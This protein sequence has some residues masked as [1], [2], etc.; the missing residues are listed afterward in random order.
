[1]NELKSSAKNNREPVVNDNAKKFV[2]TGG[3]LDLEFLEK[4][5]AVGYTMV[6]DWIE[7]GA[8]NETK[9]VHKAFADGRQEYRLIIKEV[10]ASGSRKTHRSD[11]DPDVYRE[12]VKLSKK[13]LVKRRYS[14]VYTQDDGLKFLINYDIIPD[15]KIILLEVDTENADDRDKFDSQSFPLELEFVDDNRFDGWR[16]V[17]AKV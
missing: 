3:D 2:V 10:D 8:D 5:K 12:Q 16:L 15:K 13:H 14:F 11:V 1:M 4:H 6:V 7:I 9:L 17:D